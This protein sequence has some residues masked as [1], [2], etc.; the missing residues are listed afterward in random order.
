MATMPASF[1]THMEFMSR[2]RLPNNK[3]KSNPSNN[4]N[5]NIN[6]SSNNDNEEQRRMTKLML[7]RMNTL[8]QSFREVLHEV[9]DWRRNDTVS[10]D[11][12]R[13]TLLAVPI[14][15]RRGGG[16]SSQDVKG[17]K[18]LGEGKKDGK[19]AGQPVTALSSPRKMGFD[20]EEGND[21]DGD[22]GGAG[23][24]AGVKGKPSSL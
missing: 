3:N 13:T 4:N 16:G 10:S 19:S 12:Q 14:S 2:S 23:A 24:G 5:N 15:A 8:E 1:G 11:S 22:D 18:T 17:F 6:T 7:S 20:R 9:K 21:E